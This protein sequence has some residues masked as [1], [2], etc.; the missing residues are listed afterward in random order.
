MKT[1][2]DGQSEYGLV[3]PFWI[4]TEGYSDRDR[5]MF[6]CGVEFQMVYDSVLSGKGWNQAIHNEN[7]SR[8]RMMLGNLGVPYTMKRWDDQWT[9]LT[10]GKVSKWKK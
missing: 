4:D 6:V 7:T 9:E 2:D 1:S 3:M 8:I 5:E 10:I